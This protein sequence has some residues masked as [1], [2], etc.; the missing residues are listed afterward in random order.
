MSPADLTLMLNLGW[1][2]QE[3]SAHSG[4]P[5][6]MVEQTIVAHV[7]AERLME[8]LSSSAA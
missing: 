7:K 2:L 3:I 4:L 6:R 1:T 8:K 5:V